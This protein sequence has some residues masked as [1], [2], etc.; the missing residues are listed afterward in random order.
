[1]TVDLSKYDNS[2]YNPGPALKRALWYVVSLV[3]FRTQ[4]FPF[5]GLKRTLLKWFGARVGHNVIIKPG[6]IIKYP[7][8]LQ[9]GDNTWIGEKCWIDNLANV[10][11]GNNACLSQGSMLLTGNHDYTNHAF[12][13]IVH[14]IIL[15]DGVWIGA[16]ATVCP[17][18]ICGME[19]VLTAGSV[20]TGP[21][22]AQGIYQG[23]PAKW[24]KQ[25]V[26]TT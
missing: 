4:L 25:R 8:F 11:I 9:I 24:V 14:D 21:M 7:W 5:Y 19:A 16:K 26:I 3:I 10:A 22:E 12:N 6:V 20:A 17:G 1:M 23:N 15:A 18:V 13:L 2:A